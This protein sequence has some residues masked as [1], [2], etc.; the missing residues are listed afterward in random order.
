MKIVIDIPLNRVLQG[1][2]MP[3]AKQDT[4]TIRLPRKLKAELA[5][6]A[7]AHCRPL[8]FTVR[9]ALQV[10]VAERQNDDSPQGGHS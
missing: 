4:L 2:T 9:R 3:K 8:S 10:F 5:R 6:I 7:R 1:K